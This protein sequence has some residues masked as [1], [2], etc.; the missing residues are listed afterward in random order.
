MPHHDVY[1][2]NHKHGITMK[3][4]HKI[5]LESCAVHDSSCAEDFQ[6]QDLS[7]FLTGAKMVAWYRT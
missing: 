1:T 3:L 6:V 5:V 2:R 7:K 4:G